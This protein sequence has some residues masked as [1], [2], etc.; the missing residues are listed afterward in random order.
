[1]R[2]DAP[3]RTCVN[4]GRGVLCEGLACTWGFGERERS[5]IRR[6][7]RVCAECSREG[8]THE[9]PVTRS[10][11]IAGVGR[12]RSTRGDRSTQRDRIVSSVIANVGRRG[13]AGTSVSRII[14]EAG[15]SRP[16]FYEYFSDKEDCFL[17]AL[18]AIQARLGTRVGHSIRAAQPQHAVQASLAAIVEFAGAQPVEALF[19]TSQAMG[20]GRKALDARDAGI[21][22]LEH[23]IEAAHSQLPSTVKIPDLSPQIAIGGL[24][25]LLAPRLRRG[26]PGLSRVIG[27]LAAWTDCYACAV[28]K[29]RWHR[30]TAAGD[31]TGRP[32]SARGNALAAPRQPQSSAM[33]SREQTTA[34]R[35]HRILYA[36]AQLAERKGYNATTIADITRLAGVDGRTFY[37]AF[38]DKQDAFMAVHE[39]GVQQVMSATA[40]AFFTGTSW[41]DRMW[42]AGRAFT[43][44]LESN[45]MIAHV[46]FVEAH[47]VGP[48]AV[49]RIE[50]SHVTFTIFLQEGYQQDPTRKPPRLALETIITNVFELVYRDAR[51]GSQPRVSGMLGA[52]AYLT[53]TPFLGS[54]EANRLI[55]GKLEGG[56][57]HR[58][59]A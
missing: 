52:M 30:V 32:A 59:S 11:A 20:A 29:R 24:Y 35:R 3:P 26:E 8:Q 23:L 2:N 39:L 53:L 15:V 38:A 16:T 51:S 45:P 55:D 10:S 13:Y 58:R 21:A 1:M 22:E 27:D 43:G 28:A 17:A 25:R 33:L 4:F 44:F 57:R 46:G 50:D 42:A 41:P 37:T 54:E 9:Q 56:R 18:N 6:S 14:A 12:R 40:G 19:L 34:N 49:Q 31:A 47:A 36:A 48:G 5:S 7:A